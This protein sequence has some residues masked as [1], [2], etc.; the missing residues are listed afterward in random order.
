MSP[1]KLL[2]SLGAL[3]AT[4]SAVTPALAQQ[5]T[6]KPA[7]VLRS[8]SARNSK[9]RI[10]VDKPQSEL[11]QGVIPGVRDNVK[12]VEASRQRVDGAQLLWVGF[13]PE[14]TRTRVFIETAGG[15]DYA[16]DQSKP[17]ELTLSFAQTKAVAPNMMRDINATFFQR[18]VKL[19][20]TRKQGKDIIVRITYEG[21][22]A[23]AVSRRDS[24]VYVDFPYTKSETRP[25]IDARANRNN[26]APQSPPSRRTDLD[27][28]ED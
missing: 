11:Y 28:F 19:I 17:G 8:E 13:Q 27:A 10:N 6:Q 5:T 16:L 7:T 26:G 14:D 18:G 20:E 22:L 3:L 1:P 24:Y 2:L 21:D 9:P 23:P 15:A 4:F 12:H 25:T